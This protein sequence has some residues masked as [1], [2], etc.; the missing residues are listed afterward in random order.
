MA[1]VGGLIFAQLIT[2]YL[3]PV[4]YTY[5]DGI[6]HWFRRSKRSSVLTT[7]PAPAGD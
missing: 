2:L 7:A 3:T 1:V 6:V 4:V 5:L